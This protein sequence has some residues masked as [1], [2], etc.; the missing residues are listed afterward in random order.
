MRAT[1]VSHKVQPRKNFSNRSFLET[2]T[3]TLLTHTLSSFKNRRLSIHR[4]VFQSSL[5]DYCYP[6]SGL[7]LLIQRLQA[8][9]P[10]GVWNY[11][12]V[13]LL[14]SHVHDGR[15]CDGTVS[16]LWVFYRMT[17]MIYDF[18][19]NSESKKSRVSHPSWLKAISRSFDRELA[20]HRLILAQWEYPRWSYVGKG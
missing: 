15:A 3:F 12:W 13:L 9:N 18:K 8:R 6:V 7:V 17:K 4:H 20:Q 11:D 2:A 1:S 16:L 14:L 10:L 19:I 5:R